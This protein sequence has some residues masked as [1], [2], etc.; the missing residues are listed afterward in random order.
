VNDADK[1]LMLLE[2]KQAILRSR[3]ELIAFARYMSPDPD[4]RADAL[5]SAYEAARHHRVIAAA[6]EEVE[7]GRIRR[8]IISCPPRHG[9]TR[10]ASMLFPAWFLGRNPLKSVVFATYNDKYAQ[11]VGGVVKTMLQ[12]PLYGHVFPELK[13]RYGGASNDRKDRWRRRHVLRRRRRHPDRPRRRHQP[14]RRF[15]E[16]PAGSRLDRRP[17]CG[18]FVHRN[19]FR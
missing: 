1:R 11:D 16:E 2:R 14:D 3:A 9:K 15:F 5:S 18:I 8:L 7:A 12:S 4:R 6:L 13:L 10:L 17:R 19:V